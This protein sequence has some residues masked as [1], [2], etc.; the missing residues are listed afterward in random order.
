M[1]QSGWRPINPTDLRLR[2]T[3]GI[4]MPLAQVLSENPAYRLG[5]CEESVR[6]S[7]RVGPKQFSNNHS[8]DQ[9]RR[10]TFWSGEVGE[11]IESNLA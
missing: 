5:R 7:T 11:K 1:R 10:H 9:F 3:N 6:L 4:N 2:P 8:D